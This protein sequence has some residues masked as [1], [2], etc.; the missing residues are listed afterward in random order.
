M[1]LKSLLQNDLKTAM[2]G[3]DS[4]RV[5]ALRML[6]AEIK[7]RE[8]DKRGPLDEAEVQRAVATLIKQRQE[9]IEAFKKGGRNDLVEK[10]SRELTLLQAY[11]PQPMALSEIESIVTA[12]IS[13]TGATQLSDIGKVMKA[14]L[15]KV[16]G[17]ADGKTINEI[18]RNKLSK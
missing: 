3:R 11:L 17:R 14:T 6:L 10:E 2:K 16:Q 15:A 8:I 13:E 4:V 5:G 7:K 18:A 12:A 9:S 1:D